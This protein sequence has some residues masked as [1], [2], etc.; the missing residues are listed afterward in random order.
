MSGD[1]TQADLLLHW[2]YDPNATSNPGT[3]LTG[4]IPANT[5]ITPQSMQIGGH[6][7]SNE[8]WEVLPEPVIAFNDLPA[9]GSAPSDFSF[10]WLVGSGQQATTISSVY[11]RGAVD[12]N[13]NMPGPWMEPGR[14]GIPSMADVGM[15]AALKAM[16]AGRPFAEVLAKAATL[17]VSGDLTFSITTLTQVSDVIDIK[18]YGR[19]WHVQDFEML[20]AG[21]QISGTY[22]V[23]RP[24]ED[25][26]ISF[27]VSFSPISLNTWDLQP[28]GV[29]QPSFAAW[30]FA[31]VSI[32]TVASSPNTDLYYSYS[33]GASGIA[34]VENTYENLDFHYLP[35][36]AGYNKVLDVESVGVRSRW[37]YATGSGTGLRY[38]F[39]R[40]D[41]DVVSKYHPSHLWLVTD[42]DNPLVFGIQQPAG[43]A[44]N[45]FRSLTPFRFPIF[46]DHIQFGVRDNGT[47]TIQPG[48]VA[49][50]VRGLYITNYSGATITR[51]QLPSPP[52]S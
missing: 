13:T 33:S 18:V 21:G 52:T 15:Y 37:Q 17:K 36:Q 29:N 24:L 31:V 7:P 11:L 30:P 35:P 12:L 9:A 34:Q 48:Q 45:R 44:D 28:G 14:S 26:S 5:T 38:A 3:S 25:F 47:T 32:N 42:T 39:I 41:N 51:G 50:K 2:H 16:K 20:L 1:L 49:W 46:G 10:Q 43:P 27:P 22:A 6:L 23:R 8:V 4:P 19:R 40:A